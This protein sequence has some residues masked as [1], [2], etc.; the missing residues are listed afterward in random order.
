MISDL[1]P[2]GVELQEAAARAD[3]IFK[4]SI[5]QFFSGSKKNDREMQALEALG[6]RQREADDAFQRHQKLCSACGHL[7][8]VAARPGRGG[9]PRV[10]SK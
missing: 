6:A 2:R 8:E 1:C 3:Q 5:I 10:A 4:A 7:H 9:V